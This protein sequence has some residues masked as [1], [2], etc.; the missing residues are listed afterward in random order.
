[1]IG[2]IGDVSEGLVYEWPFLMGLSV[3]TVFG[4]VLG[5]RWSD[6]LPTHRLKQSFGYFIAIMGVGIL[7][8]ELL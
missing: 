5:I 8:K 3:I 1:M 7:L 4:M 2:L 6:S